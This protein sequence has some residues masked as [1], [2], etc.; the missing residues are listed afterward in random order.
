M[1]FWCFP[2]ISDL[3]RERYLAVVGGAGVALLNVVIPHSQLWR[4]RILYDAF[5][6]RRA[7]DDLAGHI[8]H[9]GLPPDL[10]EDIDE[11]ILDEL[12]KVVTQ[13]FHRSPTQAAICGQILLH[14]AKKLAFIPQPLAVA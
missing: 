7:R 4:A 8:Q 12:M 9:L 2:I 5:A 1:A 14:V 13:R 3:V 10:V 6:L 11:D